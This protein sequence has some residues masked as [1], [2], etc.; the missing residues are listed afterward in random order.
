MLLCD[1][2]HFKRIN[3]AF[4]HQTG[5][6]SLIAFSQLLT[7][8]LNSK[9]VFARIDGEEFACLLA[10]VD[11]ATAVQVAEQIC[12]AFACLPLLK[13]GLLSVSIGVVTSTTAGYEVSR[14]LSLADEALYGA[15]HRWRNQVHSVNSS[16][17]LPQFG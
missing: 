14:L 4:G 2:D 11:E 7:Q 1:L 12:Q 9:N 16:V 10:N 8:T 6:Q 3:D 15:K 17:P 5:D 13:P